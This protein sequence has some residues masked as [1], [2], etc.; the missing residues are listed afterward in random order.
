MV[1][2]KNDTL[3]L[4]DLR[5]NNVIQTFNHDYFQVTTDT[6]KAILSPD[7]QYACAGSQ[8]GSL[9]VWNTLNGTCEQVL[10]KKHTYEIN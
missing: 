10:T 5:Q 3:N 4:I 7:G 1:C 8:D 6:H 9:F 2:L